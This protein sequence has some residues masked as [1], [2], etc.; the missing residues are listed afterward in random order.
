MVRFWVPIV[1][2]AAA[3]YIFALVD[4]A[5]I[6]RS[7]VRG[8]PK[9]AWFAVVILLPVVGAVLWFAVGRIR[10]SDL[11]GA[12]RRGPVAPDDDPAFLN[13]LGREKDV[14]DRIEQLEKE[15]R[16][17]DDDPPKS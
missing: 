9:P 10:L 8:L 5:L 2:I 13:R 4:L 7:R 16:D 12:A 6:D 14:E 1:L 11:G 17:L 3:F 15:L